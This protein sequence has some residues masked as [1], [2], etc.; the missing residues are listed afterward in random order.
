MNVS[1][2]GTFHRAG[3][4]GPAEVIGS[5]IAAR[6]L[7]GAR[8]IAAVLD[9]R[10]RPRVHPVLPQQQGSWTERVP[11]LPDPER[12]AY[13]AQVA[14]MMDDRTR[15][16]GKHT[17]QTSPAWAVNAL[18]PVPVGSAAR[19]NWEQKAAPIVAYREMLR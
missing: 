9:A 1:A 18:G 19:R 3:R 16:L 14:A 7:A 8:D 12:Q 13:L 11:R 17:A 6:D 5:A 2:S 15:R 4:P 10:I